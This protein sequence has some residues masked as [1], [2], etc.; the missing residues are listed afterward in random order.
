MPMDYCIA[1]NHV[2]IPTLYL[3]VMLNL[4]YSADNRRMTSFETSRTD[5]RVYRMARSFGLILRV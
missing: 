4:V 5:S 2:W 3:N 1:C